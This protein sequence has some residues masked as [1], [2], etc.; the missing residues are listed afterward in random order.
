MCEA[1][2]I[3]CNATDMMSRWEAMA[4]RVDNGDDVHIAMVEVQDLQ[5]HISQSSKVRTR[6][7]CSKSHSSNRLD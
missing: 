3:D 1:L 7:L 6:I 2:G 4:D 5:I